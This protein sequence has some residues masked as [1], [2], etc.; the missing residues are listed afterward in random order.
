[1]VGKVSFEKTLETTG[2]LE[3]PEADYNQK[4]PIFGYFLVEG[5]IDPQPL[6]GDYTGDKEIMQ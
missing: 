1:M 6:S 5:Q 4:T 3:S 2:K